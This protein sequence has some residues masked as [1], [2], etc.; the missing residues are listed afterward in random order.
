MAW[1]SGEG[2]YK[3]NEAYLKRT[4]GITI[5]DYEA[6]Y[7][8]QGGVCAICRRKLRPPNSPYTRGKKDGLRAE[9]DH[10]HHLRDKRKSVRGLLCG[11][12]YA[13]CNRK[14]GRIDNVQWVRNIVAYLE[15]PPAQQVLKDINE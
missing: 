15:N 14:L 3:M 6:L 4:Y 13:G 11:G 9:V 10:N 8:H 12:R 5:A 1:I 7:A 2:P